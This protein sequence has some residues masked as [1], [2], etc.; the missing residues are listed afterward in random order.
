VPATFG[1]S[2]SADGT[3]ERACYFMENH[4]ICGAATVTN[5]VVIPA[6]VP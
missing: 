1:N 4:P 3:A 5:T 2:L 6:D